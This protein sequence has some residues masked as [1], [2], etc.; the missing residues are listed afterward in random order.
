MHKSLLSELASFADKRSKLLSQEAQLW[1]EF[2]DWLARLEILGSENVRPLEQSEAPGN[3]SEITLRP[4]QAAE[5]L[6]LSKQTLAKLRVYG[7][8]PEYVKIGRRVVYRREA[9]ETFLSDRA[10]PHTSSYGEYEG[11]HRHNAR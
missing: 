6:G 9:L 3:K 8:G 11:K 5:F 2:C 1:Q 10:R 4:Q 7:G